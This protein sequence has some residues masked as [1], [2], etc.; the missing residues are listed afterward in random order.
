M[1]MKTKLSLL[2]L[3]FLASVT[4]WGQQPGQADL[5]VRGFSI[6]APKP[7]QVPAF[8]QFINEEL[9]PRGINT[10]ILRVDFAYQYESHPELR[11]S[12]A[13]SK[14]DVKKLVEAS[15]RNGIEIIPQIN[16]LGHQSWANNT[17]RL[18]RVY[19][20]FDETPWVKMPEKYQWPNEDGLYCKSYC[21]LHPGVHKVV[22]ALVDEICTAFESTAFHAGM[23]E[24]F[25]IGEAKCPRCSGHDKAELFANEV[26]KIR[27]HLAYNNRRL[28]I[29]G[30]RLIDGKQTGMGIWEA[31][32]NNTHRAVDMIPKDVM[33]CDWH[34]ERPDKTAVYFA[35]KGF[36]VVTCPWRRPDVAASQMADMINFRQTATPTMKE[37]YKGIVQTVWSD[38][39]TFMDGFYNKKKDD[40]GGNNTPWNSFTTLFV[41]AKGSK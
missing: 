37:R 41:K 14:V 18:L 22:F 27:D 24:V 23:D 40:K 16:L 29:W 13:L 26:R 30:D 4:S 11:D 36:D 35:M 31:S 5:P 10:L 7:D 33:I 8:V 6:G 21:P 1:I 20:E 39:G 38:A 9:A 28:W 17:H 2:L 25:Y 15:K 32:M 19:P 12:I 3:V 34:Y